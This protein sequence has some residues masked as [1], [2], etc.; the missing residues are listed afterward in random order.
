[1]SPDWIIRRLSTNSIRNSFFLSSKLFFSRDGS[2]FFMVVILRSEQ[3]SIKLSWSAEWKSFLCAKPKFHAPLIFLR[4]TRLRL[5]HAV[6]KMHQRMIRRIV[7][8][9]R[10]DRAN[11]INRRLSF[12][13]NNETSSSS[14]LLHLYRGV[15][16]RF[17][18]PEK[19]FEYFRNLSPPQCVARVADRC[20]HDV[21]CRLRKHELFASP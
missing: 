21:Q 13:Y 19:I 3:C 8:D 7:S 2:V 10:V 14:Y 11:I 4:K 20:T 15:G 9:I 17:K 12:L 6:K 1:M 16:Y 18:R 5:I